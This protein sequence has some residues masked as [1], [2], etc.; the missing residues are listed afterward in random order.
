M[1]TGFRN[2]PKK[3]VISHTTIFRKMDI[4]N[5]LLLICVLFLNGSCHAQ[6]KASGNF[7]VISNNHT[8][9]IITHYTGNTMSLRYNTLPGNQSGQN[10]NSFWL[11]R[12]SQV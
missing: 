8:S 3:N 10:Y 2:K 4:R 1:H 6:D 9:L 12:S 5:T 11:W 7:T